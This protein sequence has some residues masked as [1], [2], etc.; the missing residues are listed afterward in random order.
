MSQY[1]Y[2][3][4]YFDILGFKNMIN[5]PNGLEGILN[6]YLELTE[7]INKHNDS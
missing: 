1:G 2:F 6:V 5:K 7:I 3:F 4:A